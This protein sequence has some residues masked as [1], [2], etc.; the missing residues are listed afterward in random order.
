MR[1]KEEEGKSWEEQK[2]GKWEWR[3]ME[4]RMVW[5]G[6]RKVT[7]EEGQGEEEKGE[8]EQEDE[9]NREKRGRSR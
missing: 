9:E 8:L 7:K 6:K 4:R 2:M 3:E 5:T 1:R